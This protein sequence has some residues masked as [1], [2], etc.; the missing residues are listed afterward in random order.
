MSTHLRFSSSK[1]PNAKLRVFRFGSN[2][3]GNIRVGLFPETEEILICRLGFGSVALQNIGASE[4]EMGE[5]P[6]R[7]IPQQPAMVQDF[8][9]FCDC[10]R[11]LLC[12][13]VRFGANVNG[14]QTDEMRRPVSAGCDT[15]PMNDA[16]EAQKGD[17]Q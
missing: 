15:L 7:T 8:L 5:R 10:G 13:Q 6:C 12:A 9:E 11:A 2:E 4:A 14:I 1:F 3:D 16:L 17:R